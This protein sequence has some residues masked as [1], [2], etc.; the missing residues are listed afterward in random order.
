MKEKGPSEEITLE[1][2]FEVIIERDEDGLY[3][4]S[5]PELEGCHTQAR[6]MT[7]LRV[8]MSEAVVLYLGGM[9]DK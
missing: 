8:R 4:A 7:E 3:V 1:R 6:S 9:S 2:E 5:F